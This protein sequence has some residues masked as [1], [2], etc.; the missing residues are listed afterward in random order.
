[1]VA[2]LREVLGTGRERARDLL[3]KER[4]GL[5]CA[6]RL[7]DLMDA[8]VVTLHDLAVTEFYPA[9]NPSSRRLCVAAVGGYGRGTLAPGSDVDLLFLLPGRRRRGP[10]ASSR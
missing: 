1:M 3:E 9:D 8:I 5:A 2:V 10:R 6:W 4:D 7:S